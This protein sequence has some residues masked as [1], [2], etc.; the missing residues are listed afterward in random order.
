MRLTILL[1]T[2]LVAGSL[3]AQVRPGATPPAEPAAPVPR[4]GS[5]EGK[6][7]NSVTRQ[8]IVRATVYLEDFQ[9]QIAYIAT[10]D[11]FGEFRFENVTPGNSYAVSAERPGFR[12]DFPQRASPA[13]PAVRVAD[14]QHV[15]GVNVRLTPLGAIAGSVLDTAGQPIPGADVQLLVRGYSNGES[16]LRSSKLARSD[17]RGAYR[18]FDLEPGTYFLRA[19][20]RPEPF[21]VSVRVHNDRPAE[22]YAEAFY[23]ASTGA[24]GS[25][26]LMAGAEVTG[27]DFHLPRYPA[28]HIR[29]KITDAA[30]GKAVAAQ[31][32]VLPCQDAALNLTEGFSPRMQPD[33]VFDS[34]SL[35]PGSYCL[36][37]RAANP[38]GA[39]SAP[40]TVEIKDR[41]VEGVT[42]SVMPGVEVHGRARFDVARPDSPGG[43]I[44]VWLTPASGPPATIKSD[45]TFSMAGVT[46]GRYQLHVS[47]LPARTSSRS[48][49]EQKTLRTEWLT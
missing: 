25:I 29:G 17:D 27:I 9:H 10:T 11:A 13:F 7:T 31:V 6:V 32:M 41:D 22:L 39:R 18:F 47:N 49:S 3:T 44:Q 23:P 4:P 14:E 48:L 35:A 42:I 20:Q 45:N 34:G 43:Q 24:P 46:P 2:G 12:V 40:Q 5:V 30:T 37:A 16:M 15:M 28:Y 33:G 36:T 1:V 19:S 21:G 38:S 26:E 8:P